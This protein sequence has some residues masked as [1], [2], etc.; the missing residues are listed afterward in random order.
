MEELHNRMLDM[1]NLMQAQVSLEGNG[2]KKKAKSS[3]DGSKLA[4]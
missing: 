1:A 3:D 4:N 2:N